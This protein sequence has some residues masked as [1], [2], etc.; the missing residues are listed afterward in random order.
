MFIFSLPVNMTLKNNIEYIKW[1]FSISYFERY[2][3]WKKW[4]FRTFVEC[5]AACFLDDVTLD[6]FD[7]FTIKLSKSGARIL[8]IKRIIERHQTYVSIFHSLGWRLC[9][10]PS[11]SVIIYL[12]M[13][14]D[15]EFLISG[16]YLAIHKAVNNIMLLGEECTTC[17]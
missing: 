7:V 13:R 11:L 8:V 2:V 5:I 9:L 1:F 6:R 4:L 12:L 17:M 14:N 3:N 15:L 10:D 16:P